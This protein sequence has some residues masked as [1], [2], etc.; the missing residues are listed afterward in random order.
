MLLLICSCALLVALWAVGFSMFFLGLN[1]DIVAPPK[2]PRTSVNVRAKKKDCA[3]PPIVARINNSLLAGSWLAHGDP[4]DPKHFG[5]LHP[6]SVFVVHYFLMFVTIL[7]AHDGLVEY[8]NFHKDGDAT[9]M[10]DAGSILSASSCTVDSTLQTLRDV[11]A[12]FLA[13]YA[14]FVIV[15]RVFFRQE[16][17]HKS[18]PVWYMLY[19]Y[20]WLCNVSLWMGGWALHTGRPILAQ[21]LCVAVGIDQL[22]W[23]VDL[24]GYGLTRKW[25]I[26]CAKYLTWPEYAK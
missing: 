13:A 5:W 15:W 9:K 2:R 23:Y 16:P 25:P 11:T 14:A 8:Y 21:A 18:G 1:S 3:V 6:V 17:G 19:D 7:P 4:R 24:I 20:C 12:V 10:G 26:G 22:S